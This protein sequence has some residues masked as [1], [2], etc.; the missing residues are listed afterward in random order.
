M[1]SKEQLKSYFSCSQKLMDF[2][3]STAAGHQA[4]DSKEINPS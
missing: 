1:V 3:E 4:I 2:S